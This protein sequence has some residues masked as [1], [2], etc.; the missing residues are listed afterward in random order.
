MG[1]LFYRKGLWHNKIAVQ[2]DLLAPLVPNGDLQ[3]F[4]IG[5]RWRGR[6]ASCDRVDPVVTAAYMSFIFVIVPPSG[7]L[8]YDPL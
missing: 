7:W 5:P 8:T 4:G 2:A 1:N 3:P 6:S